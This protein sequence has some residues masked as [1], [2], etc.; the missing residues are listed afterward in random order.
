MLCIMLLY[1]I[2][3][4]IPIHHAD[5]PLASSGTQEILGSTM[6]HHPALV[7][8]LDVP[9]APPVAACEYGDTPLDLDICPRDPTDPTDPTVS[10]RENDPSFALT[11][12]HPLR[13]LMAI[14]RGKA[15]WPRW[16]P[17]ER[18]KMCADR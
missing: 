16:H 17:C 3:L 11:Q 1:Q 18:G 2:K 14:F 8:N 12:N 13:Y 5:I 15:T 6:T 10:E 9:S 4:V 7:R